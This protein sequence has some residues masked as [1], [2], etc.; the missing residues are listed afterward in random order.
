M[1]STPRGHDWVD[2]TQP[3]QR[4]AGNIYMRCSRCSLYV[5]MEENCTTSRTIL[6]E[7]EEEH[8][9][10]LHTRTFSRIAH[11]ANGELALTPVHSLESLVC[12]G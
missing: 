3:E 10:H 9:R 1:I 11:D 6:D 5:R 7:E 2:E 4:D 8:V 12:G